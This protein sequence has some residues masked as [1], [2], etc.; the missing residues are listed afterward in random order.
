MPIIKITEADIK[1]QQKPKQGW[2]RAKLIEAKEEPNKAKDGINY[3]FTMEIT[4][5]AEI[6]KWAQVRASNKAIGIICIPFF[7]ALL[8]VNEADLKPESFDT[9]KLAG[10]ECWCY[11][12]DDIY[13]GKPQKK[14]E[15]FAALSSDVP[16]Q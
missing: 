10:K 16:F 1:R 5:G 11:V 3:I 14:C 15:Q 7:S 6:G 12:K 2:H 8:D 4:E 13:D 9:S